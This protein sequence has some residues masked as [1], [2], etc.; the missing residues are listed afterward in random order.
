MAAITTTLRV[1][2]AF[3]C[4]TAYASNYVL[5]S[6]LWSRLIEVE[7]VASYC[8]VVRARDVDSDFELDP[9]P[10]PSLSLT[11]SLSLSRKMYHVLSLAWPRELIQPLTLSLSLSVSRLEQG[12][13]H[14]WS[15]NK[16][17]SF[18]LQT[19]SMSHARM[20]AESIPQ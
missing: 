5:G 17:A 2:V 16:L 14:T 11:L 13:E 8:V 19:F 4:I 6:T 10:L 15:A 20:Q 18:W 1:L 9:P 3:V 7:A 12:L